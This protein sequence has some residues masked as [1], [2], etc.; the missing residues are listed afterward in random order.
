MWTINSNLYKAHIKYCTKNWLKPVSRQSIT[1]RRLN[2]RAA[3]HIIKIP[4]DYERTNTCSVCWNDFKTRQPNTT[5]CSPTWRDIK[6]EIY[7][8]SEE[9]RIYINNKNLEY[10]YR[11]KIR[12]NGY[13]IDDLIGVP[14]NLK[15]KLTK[16]L[17]FAKK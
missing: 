15:E 5:T 12:N 1:K 4:W 10:Y 14:E 2:W 3:R 8:A 7:F 16:Y 11:K 17:L 6:R 9:R 13:N